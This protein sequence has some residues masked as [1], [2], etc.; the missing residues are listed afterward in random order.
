VIRIRS[1]SRAALVAAATGLILTFGAGASFAAATA[2]P[3]AAQPTTTFAQAVHITS[4]TDGGFDESKVAGYES[5]LGHSLPLVEVFGARD[6]E[7]VLQC[8]SF[9]LDPETANKQNVIINWAFFNSSNKSNE[10]WAAAAHGSDATGTPG[11]SYDQRY[12][13]FGQCLVS[14][15]QSNAIIRVAQ[16]FNNGSGG[17]PPVPSNDPTTIAN[18]KS[19]FQTF[20]NNM[21]S[22]TGGHFT[23]DYNPSIDPASPTDLTYAYPG[24]KYVDVIGLDSYD[25]AV[26]WGQNATS[27]QDQWN[28]RLNG[29]NGGKGIAFYNNFAKA[30]NKPISFPE[31]GLGWFYS[32]NGKAQTPADDAYFIQ[33][34]YNFM[35][36]NNVLYESFWEDYNRGLYTAVDERTPNASATF[37]ATFGARNS[38]P[39]PGSGQTSSGKT[40]PT[41]PGVTTPVRRQP[42]RDLWAH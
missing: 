21:R 20:V 28:R 30:H 27:P 18:F 17:M 11:V 1:R 40:S 4:Q 3:H 8:P 16:E 25:A 24:D 23:F 5:W 36:T 31:W 12:K 32:N 26:P 41:R 9:A 38:A 2:S 29:Y 14:H 33:Q 35:S 7:S 34:M 10:T 6:S 15:G 13:A 42:L 39:W 37:K 22:I 19:A